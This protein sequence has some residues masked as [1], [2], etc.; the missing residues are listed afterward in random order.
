MLTSSTHRYDFLV[1]APGLKIDFDKIKGLNEGLADPTGPVSSIYS[2][3]SVEKVW[4]NIQ[5][6][7]KG[8]AV[9][10]HG[11]LSLHLR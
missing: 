5:N 8:N 2:V 1:V 9:C 6:F 10:L 4:T 3:D 11:L 7:K